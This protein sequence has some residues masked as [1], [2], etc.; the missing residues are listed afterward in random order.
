MTKQVKLKGQV[1]LSEDGFMS[2]HGTLHDGTPFSMRVTEHDVE[3][4]DVLH[5]GNKQVDGW[6]FVVQEAKQDTR[7]YLTLPKP[8]INFGKQI[9]VHEYQLMP[10]NA[11]LADFRPQT[12][13]G[14]P[15]QHE[16]T[17]VEDLHVEEELVVEVEAPV[18]E[19]APPV[20]A[21]VEDV[22]AEEVEAPVE[23]EVAPPVEAEVEAPAEEEVAPPAEEAAPPVETVKYKKP[24]RKHKTESTP[25]N[26]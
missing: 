9:L 26:V 19:V 3:L 8:T 7:C 6:L 24:L 15:V 1:R 18:E 14:K 25:S 11:T 4:N 16:A 21:E 12:Q 20:E 23:E 2:F 10:R 22:P 17:H 13:G 5:Y